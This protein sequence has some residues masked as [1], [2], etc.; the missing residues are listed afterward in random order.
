MK[1]FKVSRQQEKWK[2]K[3]LFDGLG[4]LRR[5][6]H[7]QTYN[8]EYISHIYFLKL[9]LSTGFY[10]CVHSLF[11]IDWHVLTFFTFSQQ[12]ITCKI[13]NVYR[14]CIQ[15]FCNGL[16]APALLVYKQ[17]FP[18]I[19]LR[20]CY[21]SPEHVKLIFLVL[22]GQQMLLAGECVGIETGGWEMSFPFTE[23][24]SHLK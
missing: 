15:C 14:K 12:P 10:V 4:S 6:S 8:Y 22:R 9:A 21:Q 1:I 19:V 24:F 5:K 3:S 13:F 18:F 17:L 2:N 16:L 23:N 7:F 11:T 20:V